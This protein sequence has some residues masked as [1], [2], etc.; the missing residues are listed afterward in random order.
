ML[1]QENRSFGHYF[2]TLSGVRGIGNAH[3]S[4]PTSS[5]PSSTS[6]TP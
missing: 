2:G 3:A 4:G 1:M 6:R 5:A